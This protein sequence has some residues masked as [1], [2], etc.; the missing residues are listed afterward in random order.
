M[1]GTFS[2][3]IRH[4]Q[5]EVGKGDLEMKVTVHQPYAAAEHVRYYYRHDDGMAG[6]LE[7]PFQIEYPAM[8]MRLA[9]Q[10]VTS[11]GSGLKEEAK[12]VV[13]MFEDMVRTYAPT[14][15]GILEDSCN[16]DVYDNG[17]HSYHKEQE[18][19]FQ[20]HKE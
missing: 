19:P 12:D 5:E 20:Y 14:L 18:A 7:T 8:L 17:M 13:G 2:A 6:Y 15:S 1:A 9:A 10:A 11:S 4:L 3:R 16:L